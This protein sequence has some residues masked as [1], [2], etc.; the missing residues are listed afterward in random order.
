MPSKVGER[1]WQPISSY[2][3]ELI[4]KDQD[5]S[6]ELTNIR[7]IS[8]L[9]SKYQIIII[10]ILT[11]I[12]DIVL[13]NGL[14]EE[15]PL[16]LNIKLLAQDLVVKEQIDMELM[17][18]NFSC[19]LEPD[20]IDSSFASQSERTGVTLTCITRIPFKSITTLVNDIYELSTIK[21]VI[22]DLTN[23]IGLELEYDSEGEN[24]E[25]IDQI[26]IPP[27]TLNR[28]IDYLDQTFGLFNGIPSVFCQYDN[29]LQ[30][31]NLSKQMTK[32]QKFK[33]DL[34]TIDG[35]NIEII[36]KSIDGENFY[37]YSPI[38][39]KTSANANF[40]ALSKKLKYITKPKDLLYG[41]IEHDLND[42]CS[43]YG[44][45]SGNKKIQFDSNNLDRVKYY[46]DQT[47]YEDNESF[48]ISMISKKISSLLTLKIDIERNLPILNLLKIGEVVKF[49]TKV[50]EFVK[51]TGKYIL[52]S[53]DIVW[54][55]S[56]E[57]ETTASLIIKRTN[58]NL[59]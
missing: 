47:G 41:L 49:D 57:W 43:N 8:S 44:L 22:K 27:L 25:V 15:D 16:K 39:F 18:I 42:I 58:K 20:Q 33:I 21:E 31:K 40:A 1:Y 36:K 12:N 11:P 2:N 35:S 17:V 3:I 26:I 29:K 55:K 32:N 24:T 56:V 48:A 46:I 45:I 7:I 37:T 9:A 5:Y 51:M 10:N 59:N 23:K 14:S 53:S 13:E 19:Q 52:F 38:E 4:I 50:L 28:A 6:N 30:I 54:T 34:L